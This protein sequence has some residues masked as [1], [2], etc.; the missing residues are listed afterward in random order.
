MKKAYLTIDD[1][2][3]EDFLKKA[4]Y[5]YKLNIPVVFFCIGEKIEK[6]FDQLVSAIKMDFIIGNHSFSHNYFSN[7]S[8]DECIQEIQKTDQLIDS[9]YEKAGINR[10]HKYFRL[11]VGFLVGDSDN[12]HVAYLEFQH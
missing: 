3:S 5:L 6:H 12:R 2:P 9:L 8:L 10:I 1:A 7:L 4:N 11:S